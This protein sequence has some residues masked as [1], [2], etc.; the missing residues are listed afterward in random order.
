MGAAGSLT[1]EENPTEMADIKGAAI[2]VIADQ[3]NPRN[4]RVPGSPGTLS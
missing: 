1:A 4:E 3:I 2:T